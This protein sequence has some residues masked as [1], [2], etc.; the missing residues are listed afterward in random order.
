MN[1]LSMCRRF[2]RTQ[3]IRQAMQ[4]LSWTVALQSRG[5][6]HHA[7]MQAVT[8]ATVLSSTSRIHL[9][10]MGG[11]ALVHENKVWIIPYRCV[12][13]IPWANLSIWDQTGSKRIFLVS[14]GNQWALATRIMII[15]AILSLLIHFKTWH[16]KMLQKFSSQAHKTRKQLSISGWFIWN[17]TLSCQVNLIM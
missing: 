10:M 7:A 14:I 8:V 16:S 12:T 17:S 5:M 4:V 11:L 6:L 1:R 9:W 2:G 13:R 3:D 15:S